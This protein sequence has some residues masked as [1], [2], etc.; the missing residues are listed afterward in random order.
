RGGAVALAEGRR[1]P[2]RFSAV[3]RPGRA[4]TLPYD[5]ELMV[6]VEN[7]RFVVES[8]IARR[9]DGGPPVTSDGLRDVPVAS[10]LRQ[11]AQ[12]MLVG[13]EDVDDDADGALVDDVGGLLND[14]QSEVRLRAV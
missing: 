6:G 2:K 7:G 10:L 11:A 5:V 13:L 14:A 8:L 9:R 1:V 3:V 4:D 12:Q